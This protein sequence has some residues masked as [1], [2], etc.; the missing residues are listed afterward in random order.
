V[1]ADVEQ[2]R[3]DADCAQRG[4]AFLGRTCIG[5]VCRT[6]D[7]G[8]AGDAALDPVFGCLG[9]VAWPAERFDVKV[10]FRQRFIRLLGEV[11]VVGMPVLACGSL[12]PECA[13]VVTQ[14]LTD[15]NGEIVL[16][17]P[18]GFRGYLHM[19]TGGPGFLSMLPHL[20][21]VLPPPAADS[22]LTSPIPSSRSWILT[23]ERELNLLLGNVGAAVDPSLGH[24]NAATLDCSGQPLAGV[25]V[26]TPNEGPKTIEYYFAGL[27]TPSVSAT[28]TDSTGVVG[29][30]NVLPGVVKLDTRVVAASRHHGTYSLLVKKGS[31][32]LVDLAPTS[33]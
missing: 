20:L 33:D 31:V 3:T 29:F 30:I 1:D 4:T 25:H 12:D 16:D 19:K 21:A 26:V 28:E 17:V 11:P 27:S 14:G 7:A 5:Q 6:R 13:Q 10:R 24:I 15:G 22:D 23:S 8:D 2:C 9:S 32:T 18:L